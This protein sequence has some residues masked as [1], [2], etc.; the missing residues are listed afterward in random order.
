MLKGEVSLYSWP[1]VSPVGLA[2]FAN[3]NKNCQMSYSWFQTSQTGGQPYSD[4]SPFSIPWSFTKQATFNEV[5]NST[6]PFPSVSVPCS[7]LSFYWVKWHR[8]EGDNFCFQMK[9]FRY[10]LQFLNLLKNLILSLHEKKKFLFWFD[11]RFKTFLAKW[12]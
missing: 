5:V 12:C 1:P 2:C 10:F 4:T 9:K 3:E 6:K 7:L 8:M 11:S